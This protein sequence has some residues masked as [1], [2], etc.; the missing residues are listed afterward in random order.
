M[1]K[2]TFKEARDK[3]KIEQFIREREGQPPANQRRL[4]RLLKSMASGTK[5]PKLGTLPK[6]SRGRDWIIRPLQP[7]NSESH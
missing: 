5:K 3:N 2:L 6:G 1:K 7:H 4:K